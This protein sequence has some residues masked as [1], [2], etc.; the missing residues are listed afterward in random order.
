MDL[1]GSKFGDKFMTRDGRVA[2]VIGEHK[3]ARKHWY[4][5][6]ALEDGEPMLGNDPYTFHAHDDGIAFEGFEWLDIILKI[7]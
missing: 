7:D 1:N 6:I 3:T 2:I 4:T 5:F